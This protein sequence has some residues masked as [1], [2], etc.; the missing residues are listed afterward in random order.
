ME[1]HGMDGHVRVEGTQ[2]RYCTHLDMK[3][4]GTIEAQL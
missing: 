4:I 2:E 3:P 1:W